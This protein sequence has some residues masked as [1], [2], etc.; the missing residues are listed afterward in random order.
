MNPL[1]VNGQK[2]GIKDHMKKGFILL[3]AL[4]FFLGSTELA[5]AK[6]K[7]IKP[8]RKSMKIER[9]G[10]QQQLTPLEIIAS[11]KPGFAFN[12]NID[13]KIFDM[14]NANFGETS[15]WYFY[16]VYRVMLANVF[17]KKR[18]GLYVDVE[19]PGYASITYPF[20]KVN[21]L[22][23][24]FQ[25]D[26]FYVKLGRQIFGDK[27]D[28]LLGLQN[29][30]VSLGFDLGQTDLLVFLARTQIITPWNTGGN[31]ESVIGFVPDF[32]LGEAMTLRGY[33][34]IGMEPITI[35]TGTPPTSKDSVNTLIHAG[36]K[37]SMDMPAGPTGSFGLDAQL[38]I[39]FG[40][41]KTTSD[42]SIDAMG[43]GMKLDAEYTAQ[44]SK[45]FAFTVTGHVVYTSGDPDPALNTKT[46]FAS[47]N[48]LVGSGPGLFSK[49]Q[50]GAGPYTYLDSHLVSAKIQNY[51]GVVAIGVTGDFDF[52]FIQPGV[53]LWVYSDTNNDGK[54]LGTEFNE[55][56]V[57]Q[58]SPVVSFYQQLAYFMPNREGL[59][60]L[61]LWT[62]NPP[63]PAPAVAGPENALKFLIGSSI[64]F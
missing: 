53:G 25:Q 10:S 2:G 6:K 19:K 12:G 29:D 47:T 8:A 62:P 5:A 50:D 43:L 39:Q 4:L 41:A 55:W 17:A 13:I 18:F 14:V 30:A 51:M 58:L 42:E 49:I 21:E 45:N 27:D 1:K 28:L 23:A 15:D 24:K 31:I 63:A 9:V 22:Y 48:T 32:T 64:N 52:G 16:P 20:I 38:G 33:L 26:T 46:D 36:G 37:Y 56:L 57:Y 34:L 61:G 54:G 40:M 7:T 59:E 11:M 60:Q 35:T 44:T 3:V